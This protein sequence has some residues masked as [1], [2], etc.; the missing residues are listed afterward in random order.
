MADV[1]GA[2]RE[3]FTGGFILW[4]RAHGVRVHGSQIIDRGTELNAVAPE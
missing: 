4:T 3:K 2:I 1:I